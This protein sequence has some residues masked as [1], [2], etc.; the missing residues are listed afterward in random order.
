M[1]SKD[2]YNRATKVLTGGVSRNTIFRKPHPLYVESAKGSYIK[3]IEGVERID[4]ANNMA[5]LIHGHAHPEIIEEVTKQMHKGTAYTMGSEIEVSYAELLHNRTKSFEKI[6]FMNSGT[7]AVMTMIKAS[8]AYTGKFKIAKAEGTYH[9]TYDYAEISQTANPNNW[10]DIESPNS[11]PVVESTPDGVLNDV[12]TF[13]YNDIE[14][15]ISIL[16]KYSNDLACVLIDLVPHRVG[17]I[18][19]EDKFIEA[20][21]RWTRSNNT[22]LVFDEVVT[23]RAN[24]SGAQQNYSVTP[25]L[26]ALGKIIGGGFP[27]GALAGRSDVMSVLDPREKILKH[28]HSGTF[29]ANPIS[30]TA[31]YTAMRLFDESVV[32]KLNSLTSTAV[33]QIKE[34]IKIA[35]IPACV[36]GIGSMFRIHLTEN[37]PTTFRAAY[38]S[39]DTKETIN[40]LLDYLFLERNIIMINTCSCMFATTLTQKEVDCL[41]DALLEGFRLIKPR[42]KS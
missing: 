28:P 37:P 5:S 29:S 38:Q 34:S 8:R 26:T 15:T 23:Y 32:N 40:T 41:S 27:I 33:K 11:V 17:L 2:I 14:R 12:I 20:L 21:Y 3:D 36:T 30:M 10:G 24:Y 31:G 35:D 13:P 9:G 4:F 1:S 18:P 42:L 6:R 7:E 19:A 25:D 39:D 22:L 16:D